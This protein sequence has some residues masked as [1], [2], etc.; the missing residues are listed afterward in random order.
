M[1]V[2][3]QRALYWN[4]TILSPLASGFLGGER[5]LGFILSNLTRCKVSVILGVKQC[6]CLCFLNVLMNNFVDMILFTS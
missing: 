3:I 1:F 5:V 6:Q 2:L 4:C